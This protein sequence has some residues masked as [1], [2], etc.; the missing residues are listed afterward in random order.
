MMRN[1]LIG[2]IKEVFFTYLYKDL[3]KISLRIII[4]AHPI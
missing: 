3:S 2:V 4:D 1:E